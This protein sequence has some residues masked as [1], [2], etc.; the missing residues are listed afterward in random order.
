MKG[1]ILA[2]GMGTRLFPLSLAVS[3]QLLPVY[4]KPMV[5]YPISTLMLAGVKDILII[6]SPDA[7]PLYKTLLGNGSQW[8]MQFSYAQQE[9]P[10]GLPEAFIIGESFIEDSNVALMLGDNIIYGSGLVDKLTAG[11]G[12]KSGAIIFAYPVKD[13]E[14]F[15]IIE[16][17]DNDRPI[18][19]EEKPPHPKSNLAI[20]G[21][22]F[23][24]NDVVSISKR[25]AISPRGELEITDIIK[26]Y[27]RRSELHVQILGRGIAWLDAGT[28]TALL[29]AS[30]YVQAVE[31]RQG[32]MIAC[33]E[34]IAFRMGFI[35][36]AQLAKQAA[37][38]S[39]SEYGKYLEELLNSKY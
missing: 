21:V 4:D 16:M 24:D 35:D 20:P 2:G 6:S 22:Y 32:L 39:H 34:E 1:I 7:L 17:D 14:R 10:R 11:A 8:G 27:L 33:P 3:K 29:Q 13:P 19:I 37:L 5:Y 23:F 18:S 36:R 30:N 28:P 15:G 12:L 31:E 38:Y 25:L 9:S 26:S